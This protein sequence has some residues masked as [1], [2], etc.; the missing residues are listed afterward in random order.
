[1]PAAKSEV[2][3]APERILPQW[4]S[5]WSRNP[6]APVLSSPSKPPSESE[7][8]SGKMTRLHTACNAL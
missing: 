5:T 2:S 3:K 8:P 6:A 7:L 1:M 4:L